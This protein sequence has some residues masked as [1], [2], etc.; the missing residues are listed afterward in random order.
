MIVGRL[1]R[2][3]RGVAAVEFAM[4]SPLYFLALFGV[5]QAGLWLWT[6]F[7][8][9]RAVDAA[10]RWASIQCGSKLKT[11]PTD[12]Q[13]QT[14]AANNVAGMAVPLSAFSV[15]LPTAGSCGTQVTAAY[16]VPTFTS[17]L[18]LPNI[19]VHVSACFPT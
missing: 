3:E 14:Y 2:D 8:L 1:T 15:T 4:T 19:T 7:S 11:C 16:D 5:A 13:T 10:S 18:G 17:G 6:D 9:Q 12:S